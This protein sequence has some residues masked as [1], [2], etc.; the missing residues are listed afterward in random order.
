[1]YLK[2]M[3]NTFNPEH[4]ELPIRYA[5]GLPGHAVIRV[6]SAAGE[7]VRAVFDGFLDHI[8]GATTW[9]GRNDAGTL[10]ASGVFV[11]TIE[12]PSFQKWE[13]VIVIR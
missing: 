1:M 8:E 9:D 6:Y 7:L 3:H 4:D 13:K 12:S 5:I 11:I 10:V 2:I